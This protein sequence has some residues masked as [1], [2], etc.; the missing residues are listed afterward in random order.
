MLYAAHPGHKTFDAHAEAA[1]RDGAEAA[2]I[3]IPFEG[4]AREFVFVEALL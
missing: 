2:N 1:V 3:E 4:F